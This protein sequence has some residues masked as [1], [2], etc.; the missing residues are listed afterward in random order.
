MTRES[1]TWQHVAMIRGQ[2][3]TY[4]FAA[5]LAASVVDLALVDFV[6]GP[7]ALAPASA[8]PTPSAVPEEPRLADLA[9]A[10]APTPT[11]TPAPT[12]APTPSTDIATPVAVDARDASVARPRSR[13]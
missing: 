5:C 10:P 9:P 12:P 2:V 13:V 4:V 1:T 6:V 7:S 3:A 8:P 11:P